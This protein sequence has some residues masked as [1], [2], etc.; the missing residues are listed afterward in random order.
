ML[1]RFATGAWLTDKLITFAAATSLIVMVLSLGYLFATGSGTLDA[2]GRPLGTD[3]SNVWTAGQMALEGR[4][5]AA[6]DWSAHHDVQKIAHASSD[7]PFYGWHYP[8][9]FLLVAAAL[10]ML[11]YVPALLVWQA[12]TL[13]PAVWLATRIVP[14]RLTPLVALGFPAVYVCLGHGHNGFLTALLLG[15]GM[16]ML[17]RRPWLAGI[18]LGLL[19]YKPQFGLIVPAVLIAGLH[20]RAIGGA[21]AAFTAAS[22]ISAALWGWPVWEA[23]FNSLELT[24]TVVIEQG[25]TGWEKIQSPFAWARMWGGSTLVAYA[26]Q[27]MFTAGAIA[28]CIWLARSARTNLRNAAVCLGA[29]LS[30]PY[31]L[32]YDM[33]V[34]GVA[35]AFLV[36]DGLDHGFG[37]WEKTVIALAW[38]APLAARGVAASTGIPLGLVAMLALLI[39]AIERARRATPQS[40]P[41]V[42][43]AVGA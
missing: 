26:V 14:H 16:L 17:D 40:Q 15:S 32:D 4:A 1:T 22:A 20:W 39:V 19:A 29:L 34:A 37:R 41:S 13:V 8:P 7:V 38:F 11:P 25:A 10:A 23:F 30:T 43:V 35:I 24:R 42:A 28:A 31:L 6:Y 12:A 33:V 9:L 2:M 21:C 18:L 36:R 5:A 3:F 27:G